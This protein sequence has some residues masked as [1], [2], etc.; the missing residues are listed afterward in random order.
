MSYDSPKNSLNRK[1]LV[2]EDIYFREIYNKLNQ[3]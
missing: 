2:N 3:E 1:E